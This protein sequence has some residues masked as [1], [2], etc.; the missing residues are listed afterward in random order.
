MNNKPNE[1]FLQKQVLTGAHSAP[2][3]LHI[4]NKGRHAVTILLFFIKNSYKEKYKHPINLKI[5]TSV[6]KHKL[7][8]FSTDY[9]F[10]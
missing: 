2:Y 7:F 5:A 8:L 6:Q 10:R 4:K 3:V 1:R 9:T